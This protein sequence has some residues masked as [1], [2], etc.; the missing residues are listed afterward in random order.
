MGPHMR[1]PSMAD[2]VMETAIRTVLVLSLAF[3]LPRA[4]VAQPA[5]E[6]DDATGLAELVVQATMSGVVVEGC[7]MPADSE[8]Y[9]TRSMRPTANR[10]FDG[11]PHGT[12]REE[13]SPGTREFILRN[14]IAFSK[15]SADFEHMD[16]ALAR[17]TRTNLPVEKRW[18][19][20]RGTF[21]NLKFLHVSQDG[22][23]DFEVDF[24]RAAI[25]W[26][27]DPLNVKKVTKHWAARFYYPEPMTKQFEQL[28]RS[29][30]WGR[31]DYTRIAPKLEVIF[32]AQWPTM[33]QALEK[34]HGPHSIV[35]LRQDEDGS[36]VYKVVY[37]YH[38]VFW[39]V[40]PLDAAGKIT[41]LDY[42]EGA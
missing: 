40:G 35:F 29:M 13:E 39:T 9:G 11:R 19:A 41:A 38:V 25:E 31:P 28:L 5:A 42:E 6:S 3:G 1:A 12:Q 7:A 27:V 23:D 8:S 34:C 16:D 20:C 10:E 17:I 18:I 33:Q 30:E 36:Y 32:R 15:G 21:K 37:G 26:E 2:I 24:S 22:Y 14:I 4:A